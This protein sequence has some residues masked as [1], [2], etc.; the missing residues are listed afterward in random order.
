M[1][2]NI[3]KS[4][5]KPKLPLSTQPMVNNEFFISAYVALTTGHLPEGEI[6]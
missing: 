4:D 3:A 5:L 1:G 2:K 6:G